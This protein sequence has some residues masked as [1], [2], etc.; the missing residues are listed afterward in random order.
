MTEKRL[1][2]LR[3]ER[4]TE[5]ADGGWLGCETCLKFKNPGTT[6]QSCQRWGC[7]EESGNAER[8][9][10]ETERS[11]P[12]A[13]SRHAAELKGAHLPEFLKAAQKK[14][15]WRR[16]C[17]GEGLLSDLTLFVSHFCF[18]V[19]SLARRPFIFLSHGVL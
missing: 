8:R 5:A 4:L 2:Q 16:R 19:F 15:R 13:T 6:E 17:A 10:A 1:R 9:G 3:H 14:R 7:A 18:P 11:N 12:A